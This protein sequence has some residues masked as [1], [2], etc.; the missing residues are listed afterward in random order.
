MGIGKKI[1][2]G[3]MGG[4]VNISHKS[5]MSQS[6]KNQMSFPGGMPGPGN[7]G[8]TNNNVVGKGMAR[9]MAGE[10]VGM[11]KYGAHQ[12]TAKMDPMYNGQPGVQQE[13]FEQFSAPKSTG[14][15][16]RTRAE[17]QADRDSKK[18]TR[19]AKR[20]D[21]RIKRNE[22]KVDKLDKKVKE[23]KEIFNV[24]DAGNKTTGRKA[25]RIKRAKKKIEANKKIS[26][27]G[28]D[29]KKK[30][31]EETAK[32][33]KVKP[34]Q[35]EVGKNIETAIDNSIKSKKIA[36]N[37]PGGKIIKKNGVDGQMINGNFV[38]IKSE[39]PAKKRSKRL[40]DR[41]QA[42]FDKEKVVKAKQTTAIKEGKD[43]KANRLSKKRTR[44]QEKDM[45]L[46]AKSIKKA[47]EGK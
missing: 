46:Q 17:R 7:Y 20:A 39:G 22:K 37:D 6:A 45:R 26:Q 25:D 18:T 15:A 41:S 31:G 34:S 12:G 44:L 2:K 19:R 30:K 5:K 14:P 23:G 16:K 28:K 36:D 33:V 29:L 38:P 8:S 9:Y 43:K 32:K 10:A 40:A 1:T 13:D 47:S 27:K 21:K 4:G 35:K 24:D 42:A 11:K 3:S